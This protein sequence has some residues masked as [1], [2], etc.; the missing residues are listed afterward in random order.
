MAYPDSYT[1]FPVPVDGDPLNSPDQADA[2]NALA[3]A[4]DDAAPRII[5][6][7]TR[8][9]AIE[10]MTLN[11]IDPSTATDPVL[12]AL[13]TDLIAKGWMAPS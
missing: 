8:I 10:G 4:L 6:H 9:T 12:T 3:T 13:L 1:A 5:D 11:Y 2:Y 7:E